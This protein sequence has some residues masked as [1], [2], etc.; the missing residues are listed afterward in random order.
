ME[1][2]LRK[3]LHEV[4]RLSWNAA[5]LAHNSH[6]PGQAEW[7]RAG[8]DTLF[9]EELELLGDLEGKRLAHLQC[10]AGPDS[11]CLARR[12]AHVTGVDISDEAID[13]ARQLSAD[14]GIPA[15][16]VRADV[17]DWLEESA[18]HAERYDVAF[19]SYGALIWLSDIRRWAKGIARILEP[20]GA[21]VV[22]EFHPFGLMFNEKGVMDWPYFARAIADDGIGDYVAAAGA[23]LVPWGFAEG[24]QGFRNPNPSHEF[25]RSLADVVQAVIDAG[26]RLEVL[27][28][29]P[30]SNG[31]PRFEDS[32]EEPG[33]RFRSPAGQQDLPLMYGLRARKER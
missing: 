8:G 30:Y 29:Y 17:Y 6:K 12:G 33:R 10:N 18:D 7:I 21:L 24:V 5:T 11:V 9:Q 1:E 3:D 13:Y 15:T 2:Q 32:R 19:S 22:V 31:M 23:G 26:L 4:N 25:T 20:G 27:A 16:F 14:T 28:E